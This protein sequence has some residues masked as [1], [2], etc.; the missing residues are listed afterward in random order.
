MRA[1]VPAAALA[2]VA[3][4]AAAA[5]DAPNALTRDRGDVAYALP[6]AS[7]TTQPLLGRIALPTTRAPSRVFTPPRR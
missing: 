3:S 2:V 4:F 5:A 1:I 6:A 7:A